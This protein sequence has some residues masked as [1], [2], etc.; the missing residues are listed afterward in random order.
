MLWGLSLGGCKP[1]VQ[2]GIVDTKVLRQAR[3]GQLFP[4]F[5]GLDSA[6]LCNL[7]TAMCAN[8]PQPPASK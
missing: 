7:L 8:V 5:F 3:A 1:G 6:T 2:V 4:H